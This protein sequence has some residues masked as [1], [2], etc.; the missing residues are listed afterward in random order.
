MNVSYK[1]V[2]LRGSKLIITLK[3]LINPMTFKAQGAILV[4]SGMDGMRGFLW[5]VYPIFLI[6]ILI[7]R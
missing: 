4:S 2:N 7:I 3:D 5:I 1:P 6:Y